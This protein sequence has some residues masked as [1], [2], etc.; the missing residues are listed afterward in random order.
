[1]LLAPALK[2]GPEEETRC[3]AEAAPGGGRGWALTCPE[4]GCAR[5]VGWVGC[6]C[7]EAVGASH[8]WSPGRQSRPGTQAAPRRWS[9]AA[10]WRCAGG[11]AQGRWVSLGGL[12]CYLLP[13]S[14]CDLGQ[15]SH[16]L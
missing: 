7:W 3:P 14:L 1:M 5:Q 13:F 15:V 12:G 2:L 8:W 16:P 4:G 6:S 11:S 9:H 10:G